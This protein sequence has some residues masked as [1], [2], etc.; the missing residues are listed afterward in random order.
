MA[1]LFVRQEEKERSVQTSGRAGN[2]IETDNRS[3][4]IRSENL[5]PAASVLRMRVGDYRAERHRNHAGFPGILPALRKG[6]GIFP[7]SVILNPR[8]RLGWTFVRVLS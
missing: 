5:S 8:S 6:H 1:P 2:A 3:R 4:F 7:G